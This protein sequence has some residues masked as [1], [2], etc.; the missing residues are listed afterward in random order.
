VLAPPSQHPDGPTY[1]WSNELAPATPPARLLRLALKPRREPPPAPL[2]HDDRRGGAAGPAARSTYG[3]AALAREIEALSRALP[4][5]RNHALNRAS[6]SLHQLV[7]GGEL[8]AAEVR[9]ALLGAAAANGLMDDPA[10]GPLSVE[11]TIAS[12]A[13]A[14]LLNPRSRPVRP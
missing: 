7:A 2:P 1:R 14:G 3:Q 10:D 11:K 6:F 8:D 13:C 5:G 4:G 12:G 9:R